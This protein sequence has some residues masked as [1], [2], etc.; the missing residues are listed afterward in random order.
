MDFNEIK[1]IPAKS[2]IEGYNVKGTLKFVPANS[3]QGFNYG[4]VLYIPDTIK[5]N[6]TLIIEAANTRGGSSDLKKAIENVI[7]CADDCDLPIYEHAT[8]LGMPILYPIFP[9]WMNGEEFIWNHMLSSNSLNPKTKKLKESGLKRVDLQLIKMIDDAKKKFKLNDINIDDKVIIDGYSASAKFANRFTLLHPEIVKMCIGGGFSGQ[10]TL[11]LEKID[12]EKLFWPIGIGNLDELI[13][14]ELSAEQVELFKTIPQFYYIGEGDNTNDPFEA[15]IKNDEIIPK[16]PNIIK[17][18]EIKQLCQYIGLEIKDR[19]PKIME[20]YKQLGING[21]F[22]V[23]EDTDHKT[24]LEK[25]SDD[26]S[27]FIDENLEKEH[28]FIK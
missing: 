1:S 15:L 2:H 5:D 12:D 10:L 20:L 17:P 21:F 25:A 28:N 4:Y 11:P 18:N 6:T 9:R 19:V 3:N 13:G 8:R 22:K 23:Y 24:C 14:E 7:E 16:N 26:I 27:K